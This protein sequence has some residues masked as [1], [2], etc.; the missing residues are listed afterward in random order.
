MESQVG[1]PFYK[2]LVMG[3]TTSV[4]SALPRRHD[5]GCSKYGRLRAVHIKLS[6]ILTLWHVHCGPR[7]LVLI[8]RGY[9][10]CSPSLSWAPP[11]FPEV[12]CRLSFWDNLTLKLASKVSEAL[13]TR[14]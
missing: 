10:R 2:G 13:C 14:T 6:Q 11:L 7:S 5:D 1:V 4:T 9:G 8:P 3:M 12:V